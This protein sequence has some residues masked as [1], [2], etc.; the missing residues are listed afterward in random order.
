M[1]SRRACRIGKNS[2]AQALGTGDSIVAADGKVRLIAQDFGQLKLVLEMG[3]K[4]IAFERA[5]D[6][7]EENGVNVGE[8]ELINLGTAEDPDFAFGRVLEKGCKG[9]QDG[10]TGEGLKGTGDDDVFA[11]GQR[12]AH[13]FKGEATH[14]DGLAA[15][16]LLQ[17]CKILGDV[18]WELVFI[19][20]HAVVG[21]GGDGFP[22]ALG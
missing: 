14:G 10:A 17:P 15:C 2:P 20:D 22:W 13:G 4:G 8:C 12:A 6:V 5:F 18:P 7:G 1:R 9:R 11:V 19:A 21:H 3:E 16:G